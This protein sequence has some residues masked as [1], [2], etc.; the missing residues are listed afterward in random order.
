M[1]LKLSNLILFAPDIDS[2]VA[3]QRV[4]AEALT[5]SLDRIT[6]YTNDHDGAIAV[7]KK[8]F[9]STDRLGNYD[10]SEVTER[11]K[12][13]LKRLRNADVIFYSGGG[14][15]PLGHSYYKSPAVL[16]DC[17][18]LLEGKEP[19]ASKGRPL[20]PLGEHLW[21]IDDNYLK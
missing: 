20:K 16:S 14:G 1:I 7:S 18:L 19:G 6:L 2:S 12:E 3:S 5:F 11:Q 17:F 15:G 10:V 4:I 8:L 21:V 13:S 9:A